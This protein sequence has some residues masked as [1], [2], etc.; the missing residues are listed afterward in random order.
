MIGTWAVL[1]YNLPVKNKALLI[2]L[3][4]FG[5][6]KDYEGNAITRAHTKTLPELRTKFPITFLQASG[7][8]VGVPQGTQGGSEVGHFTIGAGRQV[9]QTLEAINQNIENGDFYKNPILKKTF[10]DHKKRPGA[11]LHLIG[12]VS[13]QGV[14]AHVAHLIALLTL[15]KQDG[16]TNIA[17]HA[18]TDGRDVPMKS[19]KKYIDQVQQALNDLKISQTAHIATIIGRYYAMD[20][21]SNWDRLQVAYDLYVESKGDKETDPDSAID[22]AYERGAES[23]YY[24]GPMVLHEAKI[25]SHDTVICFNFRTDRVR[26]IT[27]AF[28]GEHQDTLTLRQPIESRPRPTYVCFGDYSKVAPVLFPT[29]TVKNNLATVVSNANKKQFKIGETEKYA[30]V[31]YFFN[32]QIE[33]PVPGEDRQLIASPKCPSYAEKPAMSAREITKTLIA[34][35]EQETYE[36]IV[37]N[38]ANLDLV[39]HSGNLLSTIRAV[40]VIDD[41]LGKIV[42]TAMEHGYTVLITGDHGNAEQMLYEDGTP[43]PSHTKNLVPCIICAPELTNG[44]TPTGTLRANGALYDVAPTILKILNIA[45]PTEM[46]GTSLL[47]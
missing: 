18:I 19:A 36:F 35:V 12:L 38:F 30:H 25:T 26:Q 46:T 3:D 11:T 21:D 7:H 5:E 17:I 15:A 34:T 8:A 31:T 1:T 41:C 32:S 27:S 45:Q 13:D 33:E 28:T 20:R 42:P 44:A 40:E 6:G 29:P 10:E 23:D 9:F 37:C 24:I 39:G 2:I 47:L 22:H 14:H 4:G 43:C 16:I